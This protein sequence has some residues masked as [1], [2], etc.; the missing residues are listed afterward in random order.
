MGHFLVG[1]LC[2]MGGFCGLFSLSTNGAGSVLGMNIIFL[3]NISDF[4]SVTSHLI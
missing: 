4:S 2:R 1:T 3:D